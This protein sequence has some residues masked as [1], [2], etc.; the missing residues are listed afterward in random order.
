MIGI[1]VAA[2][3]QAEQRDLND[4]PDDDKE[5][6]WVGG[7]G[8]RRARREIHAGHIKFDGVTAKTERR[9]FKRQAHLHR[10]A[11]V[12]R[13]DRRLHQKGCG[14]LALPQI[15]VRRRVDQRRRTGVGDRSIE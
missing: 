7:G 14:V 3:M 10:L 1:V 15:D 12:D 8:R 6:P 9:Q 2:S 4:Q 11:R 13:A 5:E